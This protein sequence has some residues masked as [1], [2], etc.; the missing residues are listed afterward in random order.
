MAFKISRGNRTFGDIKF[1]EDADTGIDFENDIIK[2]ETA[3]NEVL[4]VN[5]SNVGIGTSAPDYTLDVAGD[6]GVNQYIYH[7]GDGNTWINFTDNR[8]RLNAGGNNFI[9]C[10]DP[11][12]APHKVRINNGGNNIDFVIKDSSNNVYFTA[13]AS[14]SRIGI[15]TSSP[16]CELHVDGD[17]KATG[18]INAKQRSVMSHKYTYTSGSDAIF[19]RFN[20][21]GSNTSGGVNNN[22]IAPVDGRLLKILIRTDGTPGNTEIA[23]CKITNGTSTFGG[24]SPSADVMLNI[25][26]ANTTYIA[27]F[28]GLSSPHDVTFSE[29][30][31]LGIRINPTSNHGNVDITTVW[32]F[33]WNT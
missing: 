10:E 1:E 33:D 19:I 20:A 24:G 3:G 22:F 4:V 28:S 23:F 7:N 31:V 29:G 8:I 26:S 12:S 2:L 9:D 14:T 30:N 21:A 17:I 15:G 5:G 25:S 18:V 6:I 32:E 11:G 27:D 16:E 13:D